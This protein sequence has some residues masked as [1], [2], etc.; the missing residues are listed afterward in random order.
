MDVKDRVLWH[1][2]RDFTR[3]IRD[4]LWNNIYLSDGMLALINT[5]E[6]QQLGRIKQ[7]GPSCM[8]SVIFRLPTV[9]RNF[10]LPIMNSS[11]PVSSRVNPSRL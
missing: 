7:L 4:P 3:P 6:F 1:L 2:D 10:R 5:S 11:P 8:I 9:S